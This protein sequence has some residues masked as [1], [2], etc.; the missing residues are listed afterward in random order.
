MQLDISRF[1]EKVSQMGLS[2][3]RKEELIRVAKEC[4]EQANVGIDGRYKYS[5]ECSHCDL[6]WP[7]GI[8]F[9]ED[10]EGYEL[11]P[12]CGEQ[13]GSVCS[14]DRLARFKKWEDI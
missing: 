10:E 12:V 4:A 6:E 8:D 9:P 2:E 13:I 11:C 3:E 14:D 1:L 7:S 5:E